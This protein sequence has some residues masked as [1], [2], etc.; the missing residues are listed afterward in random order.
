[1]KWYKITLRLKSALSTPLMGDTLFGHICW[2]IRFRKGEKVLT[3]FLTLYKT[4][5]PLVLSNGFPAGYLPRPVLRP[6]G[7]KDDLSI[8][9]YETF[10]KYKKIRFLPAEWFVEDGFVFSEETLLQK[11]MTGDI[12]ALSVVKTERM[13]NSINRLSGTVLE[14]QS[15]FAVSESWYEANQLFNVYALSTMSRDEVYTLFE[16]GLE[17]GYGADASTGKGWMVVDTVE[18]ETR[19]PGRGNR[20][21]ALGAF[22]PE[23]EKPA[24][25]RADIFTKF[26]KL[27]GSYIYDNN[28]FKKPLLMYAEGASMKKGTKDYCGRMVTGIHKLPHIVH[29][30]YAPLVFFEEETE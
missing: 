6:A 26:G 18:E 15:P 19:L 28:P 1:M 13:H 29:H 8:E 11:M 30:A 12:K 23:G 5:P 22:V 21:M 17:N 9:E 24:E 16:Q 10:K 3:D 25:L 7:Y 14:E 27:G 20:A 4:Q 2:G